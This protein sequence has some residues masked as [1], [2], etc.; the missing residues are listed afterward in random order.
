MSIPSQTDLSYREKVVHGV[1]SAIVDAGAEPRASGGYIDLHGAIDAL[2]AVLATVVMQSGEAPTPKLRRET[3]DYCRTEIAKVMKA[4]A[5]GAPIDWK[6]EPV[7]RR[8]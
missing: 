1:I 4:I 8:S 7:G 5:D 6:L 3:A 2:C